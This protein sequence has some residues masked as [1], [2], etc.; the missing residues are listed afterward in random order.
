MV[1]GTVSMWKPVMT[2]TAKLHKQGS[3]GSFLCGVE[4]NRSCAYELTTAC[5]SAMGSS[6]EPGL[7]PL[8]V[9]GKTVSV[10]LAEVWTHWECGVFV[11]LSGLGFVWDCLFVVVLEGFL[12]S[13]PNLEKT[14]ILCVFQ[15]AL[16]QRLPSLWLHLGWCQKEFRWLM[17]IIRV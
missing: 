17:S 5:W 15:S 9:R 1:A 2:S 16:C 3:A 11:S 4:L 12:S 8:E 14:L 10:H 7:R 13:D 6:G